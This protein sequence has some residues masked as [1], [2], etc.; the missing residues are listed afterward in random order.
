MENGLTQSLSESLRRDTRD[1][2]TQA[3]RSAFMGRLLRG[4]MQRPAYVTLLRNLHAIY[5]ALEPALRRHAAHTAIAPLMLPGLWREEPLRRDLDVLHGAGWQAHIPLQE[6]TTAYVV[7]LLDIEKTN[8]TLL[9]A[10]SYVRYLGDLSGGQML[11]RIVHES[12]QLREGEGTAFYDFGD[13]AQ[14]AGL[15][16]AY[17]AGL[18]SLQPDAASAQAIVAE[19]KRAFEMHQALFEQLARAEAR[20]TS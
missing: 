15:K 5:A 19:A 3:E 12:L 11:A 2:H 6:A 8:P 17:R 13:A 9:A 10:H 16:T 14:T 18:A 4:Q 7:R 1:L 20:A